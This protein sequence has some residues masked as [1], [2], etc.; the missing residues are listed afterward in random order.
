MGLVIVICANF[1]TIR[2]FLYFDP[3]Q[4]Q[5]I[6]QIMLMKTRRQLCFKRSFLVFDH[7][8]NKHVALFLT[9]RQNNMYN[10]N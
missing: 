1:S 10:S 4:M 8:F 7:F 9:K 6:L 3:F 2:R 5:Y